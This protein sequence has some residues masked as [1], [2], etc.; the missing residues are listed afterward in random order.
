MCEGI[1]HNIVCPRASFSHT[2]IIEIALT[3]AHTV[4]Q[5]RLCTTYTNKTNTHSF[6][7]KPVYPSDTHTQPCQCLRILLFYTPPRHTASHTPFRHTLSSLST[8]TH[9]HTNLAS[10]YSLSSSSSRQAD[11]VQCVVQCSVVRWW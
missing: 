11:M 8:H 1:H 2:R 3:V 5:T 10:R 6:H 7:T 9:A 4:T